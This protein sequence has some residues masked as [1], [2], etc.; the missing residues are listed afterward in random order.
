MTPQQSNDLFGISGRT[1]LFSEPARGSAVHG[2]CVDRDA[3]LVDALAKEVNG[4]AVGGD[5]RT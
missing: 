5:V 4:I 2:I 3:A 1:L